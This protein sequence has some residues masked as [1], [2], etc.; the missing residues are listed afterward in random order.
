ME[1]GALTAEN[2]AAL[3]EAKEAKPDMASESA[4]D[5]VN[6]TGCCNMRR[7]DGGTTS[8]LEDIFLRVK[9]QKGT[10]K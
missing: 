3:R 2:E 8:E 5:G 4:N 10:A 7:G 9:E 1:D 6:V